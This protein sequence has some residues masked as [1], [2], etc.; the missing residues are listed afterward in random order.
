MTKTVT[1]TLS[2]W[3]GMPKQECHVFRPEKA[4]DLEKLIASSDESTFLPRGLGRAY[5]DA[6]LNENGGA[7]LQ[8]RLNRLISFDEN[9]G[10]VECE[11]GVSLAEII[12]AFLPRGWF[13]PVSPGTKFVTIGGAVACD[14]H[15]KN[16]HRDGSF[17]AFVDEFDLLT[18][19]GETLT[20]SRNQNAKAFWAT[21]GGMGLTGVITR[22][23]LQLRKVSTSSLVV[24]YQQLPNLDSVLEQMLEDERH[25][26]SVAWIDCLASGDSLG[27]GV[28]M[29]G[30]HAGLDELKV[31]S[32]R[33]VDNPLQLASSSALTV[34]IDMPDFLLNSTTV[35]AFNSLFYAAHKTKRALVDYEKYFYPL[36]SIGRWNRLYG[37]AGF[38]QYQAALPAEQSAAGLKALLEAVSS[39]KRAS[40]LAVLKTFGEANE[41][42][43]SFPFKGH[44]LTFDIPFRNDLPEFVR[45]LDE[46]TMRFGGR[47]YLAKDALLSAEK[48]RTM[49]PRLEEWLS[50]KRELDPENRF[51][52]SLARRLQIIQ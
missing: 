4:R 51:S 3:G 2:G 39:S 20:C 32:P 52:S 22:V 7:V 41:A 27:R 28:L 43:L 8:E 44:T 21:V 17:S 46:I 31:L 5:G 29:R 37:K 26:Y 45:Q 40:F 9:S 50:V 14:I 42:P 30:E 34:P 23:Q 48:F 16:H 1:Q 6:A 49:Y 12:E 38:I 15:G 13:L 47:V 24:N 18:A 36:D 11:G 10:V 19:N 25:T 33:Q 35:G